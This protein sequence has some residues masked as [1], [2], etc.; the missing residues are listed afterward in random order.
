M[1]EETLLLRKQVREPQPLS[2]EYHKARKQLILWAGVLLI[3]ELVGVDL[4]KAEATGGNVGA[5]LSA[6]KSPQ[7]I[8]WVLA[9]IV[10]Y[11]LF[12]VT[13]EWYQ[14][15]S[16]RRSLPVARV[17][18]LSAWI[19]SLAA[20]ALYFGQ[21]ISRAQLADFL[22][23]DPNLVLSVIGGLVAGAFLT[24][25]TAGLLIDWKKGGLRKHWMHHVEHLGGAISVTSIV[26]WL[27]PQFTFFGY[28]VTRRPFAVSILI[29]CA[30]QTPAVIY[31]RK[32]LPNPAEHLLRF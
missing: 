9:V 20:Y 32:K 6:I 19:I 27:G 29:G 24:T 23:R 5:I 25:Y 2:G 16:G 10:A 4:A 21:K 14:C 15:N 26:L 28:A 18:F 11:F 8:P 31:L 12:K 7:A 22:Q 1:P 17:D 13:V 3:W 30:L